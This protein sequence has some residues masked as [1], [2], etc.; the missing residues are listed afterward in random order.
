LTEAQVATTVAG[1]TTAKIT[2][3][4]SRSPG[5]GRATLRKVIRASMVEPLPGV[6]PRIETPAANAAA[7]AAAP[8]ATRTAP[9][10]RR[11]VPVE[12]ERGGAV[13]E[14]SLVSLSE[15]AV[16]VARRWRSC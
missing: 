9:R 11:G 6:P 16:E 7:T 8:T 5:A 3:V 14:E 1:N 13:S 4:S 10:E 12:P 15:V 2:S